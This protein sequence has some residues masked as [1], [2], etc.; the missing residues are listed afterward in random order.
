MT[1]LETIQR[2]EAR[3]FIYGFFFGEAAG[4]A[5]RGRESELVDGSQK[6]GTSASRSMRATC[7]SDPRA[8]LRLPDE[9]LARMI[10][11]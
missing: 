7:R 9:Y 8:S 2:R 4:E 5:L 3:E 11:E 10:A 1:F 6:F